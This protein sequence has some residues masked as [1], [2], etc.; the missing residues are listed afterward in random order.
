MDAAALQAVFIDTE[1]SFMPQRVQQMAE[2]ASSHLSKLAA[3]S[4]RPDWTAAAARSTP[5]FFTDGIHVFSVHSDQQLIATLRELPNFLTAHPEVKL[6][7]LDSIAAP[8][9]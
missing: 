2:A 8:L 3:K 5:Q 1:G 9:R 4:G 6:V 7:L